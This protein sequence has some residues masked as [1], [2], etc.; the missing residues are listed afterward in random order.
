MNYVELT[1]NALTS[2]YSADA[3]RMRL[4][5][6]REMNNGS[7]NDII[8]NALERWALAIQKGQLLTTLVDHKDE[9]Q[10]SQESTTNVTPTQN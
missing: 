7:D 10:A 3:E 4:E 2:Q 8:D 5:V 1:Y 6:I 9:S